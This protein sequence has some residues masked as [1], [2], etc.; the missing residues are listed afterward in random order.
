VAKLRARTCILDG[1]AVA[2]GTDGIACFE[3]I[4]SWETDHGVF[5]YAFDLIELPASKPS[6]HL[7]EQNRPESSPVALL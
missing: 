3:L 2:C 5:M 1:E 6:R 4:R 7:E